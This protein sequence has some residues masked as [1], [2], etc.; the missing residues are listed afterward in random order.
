MNWARE[1]LEKEIPITNVY[2]QD[3]MVD[4]IGVTK[5]K[6]FKGIISIV[7]SS[8]MYIE[9]LPCRGHFTLAL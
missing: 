7:F 9:S 5:G 4:V 8:F 1:H 6:G 2:Q 3:E